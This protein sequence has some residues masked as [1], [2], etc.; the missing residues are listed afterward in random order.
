MEL[1]LAPTC[2]LPEV[3]ADAAIAPRASASSSQ[4]AEAATRRRARPSLTLIVLTARDA[5]PSRRV[6]SSRAGFLSPLS[7]RE[8]HRADSP[9]ALPP[10][11]SSRTHA[12]R[13][14]GRDLRPSPHAFRRPLAAATSHRPAA[15]APPPARL[16][17]LTLAPSPCP[18]APA[19]PAFPP[20]TAGRNS[21]RP[22]HHARWSQPDAPRPA[23][24]WASAVAGAHAPHPPPG[25]R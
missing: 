19:R 7:P 16:V 10:T 8:H 18:A 9:V 23:R 6:S 2:P 12:P 14:R 1:H 17:A 21:G 13:R 22:A 3:F 11:A 15:F 25:A 5:R 20:P 4:R 24:P